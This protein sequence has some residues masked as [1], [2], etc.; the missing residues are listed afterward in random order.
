MR[1]KW[2]L[3]LEHLEDRLTPATTGI[4]WPDPGHL[5]LSFMPDGADVGGTPSDLYSLL[6]A[7]APTAAWQT[8]VLRAMQTWLT[9]TNIN[10]GLVAD[11][12]Q[13]A[14]TT[15]AI[16][17]DSRFGDIRIAAK[18]LADTS[19]STAA[20]FNYA[21]STWAGDVQLSD[22]AKFSVDGTGN[23]N[24]DLYTI[25]LHELAHSLG[26]KDTWS[27]QS[28]VMF[29]YYMG[30]RAGLNSQDIA[31]IQSLYGVRTPDAFDA[32]QPNDS[33]A[34]AT[35]IGNTPSQLAFDAD[36]TTSSDV[37]YY[38]ISTPLTLLGL[39]T[40][41]VQIQSAGY[42]LLTPMVSIYDAAHRL[43]GTASSTSPLDNNIQVSI[44]G[45]L[46]LSTYYIKVEHATNDFAV[47]GYHAIISYQG[48]VNLTGVLS[49]TKYVVD[50]GLNNLMATATA[51]VPAIGAKTDQ[52]F[53]YLYRANISDPWDKDY[54]QIQAPPTNIAGPGIVWT[55]HTLVWA[56]DSNMLHPQVHLFDAA[57][58]PVAIQVVANTDGEYS[59][60]STSLTPGAVYYLD[61]QAWTP[62][63]ANNVGNYVLAVKFDT[64][65]PVAYAMVEASMLSSSSQSNTGVLTIQQNQ[66]FQFS[67]AADTF[68]ASEDAAVTLTVYDSQ[69]RKVL[70]L[71]AVAGRPPVTRLAYLTTGDYT[72]VYT[73]QSL[74]GGVMPPVAY[75]FTG[76]DLTEPSGPYYANPVGAAPTSGSGGASSNGNSTG[77]GGSSAGGGSSYAST[78]PS[79]GGG[80]PYFY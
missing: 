3:L 16:E 51:L 71:T 61:V 79:S 13:P 27:D 12:G 56:A 14:G 78:S 42:S 68:D 73:A 30:A 65:A 39:T 32:K 29:G 18:N 58:N 57:G 9:P 11:G 8:A 26:I 52:R 37:D 34:S 33:F 15:G 74:S 5:T 20:F 2:R 53:D 50:F 59:I 10:V 43:V 7:Q 67:L 17:G 44:P 66:L 62:M 47:G 28:T 6:N 72:I 23:G 35:A 46:P 60:E 80:Q 21:G 38:K 77:S 24:I 55:M 22:Q 4:T 49:T 36:L 69:G 64:S 31:D 70:S 19:L 75:W 45:A 76:D 40:I 41:R 48:G 1:R 54:Y 63:G 25:A